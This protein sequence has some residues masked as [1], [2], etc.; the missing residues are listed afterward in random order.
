MTDFATARDW[1]M[2]FGKYRGRTLDAIASNDD[3]LLYLDWLRGQKDAERQSS[4]ASRETHRM[5]VAYLDDPTIAG[6]L[7]KLVRR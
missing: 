3:G 5:L 4:P 2:P 1:I 7:A 6:D